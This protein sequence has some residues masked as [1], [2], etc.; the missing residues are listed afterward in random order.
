MARKKKPLE[1]SPQKT[2]R[3]RVRR[4][5]EGRTEL[6]LTEIDTATAPTQDETYQSL[7]QQALQRFKVSEEAE[8]RNRAEGLYDLKFSTGDGQWPADIKSQRGLD[9]RPCLTIPRL[10]QFI[11]LVSN[12][13]IQS[14]PAAQVNP[15]GDQGDSQVASIIQGMFRHIEDDSVAEQVYSRAFDKMLRKGW[16]WYRVLTEW[17]GEDSWDQKIVV[18]DI[19]NDFTV[20]CDPMAMLPDRSDAEWM[21]IVEDMP[22]GA[23]KDAYGDPPI[24]GVSQF[25]SV[26]DSPAVWISGQSIRVAEYYY[27]ETKDEVLY[28]LANGKGIFQSDVKP[29]MEFDRD[30]KGNITSRVATKR[31]LKWCKINANTV[32]EEPIDVPCKWIPVIFMSGQELNIDGDRVLYGMVR[33]ARDPQRMY[34]YWSSALTEAIALAPKA[35]FI[36]AAGQTEGFESYWSTANK[37]NWP[38]LPYKFTTINGQPAPKPERANASV[39]TNSISVAIHQADSDL[40]AT[41]GIYQPSLGAVGPEQSGK[42]ILARQKQSDTTNANYSFNR[43]WSLLHCYRVILDMMPHIYTGARA[44]RIVR[45][46]NQS[47]IV[48]INQLFPGPDGREMEYDVAN[49]AGRY[50]VTLSVGAAATRRQQAVSM[51]FEVLKADPQLITMFGDLLM[52]QMDADGDWKL[53]MAERFRKMLPPQLQDQSQQQ[54]AQQ[55]QQLQQL[56]QAHQMLTQAF[57]QA[58]QI[59]QTKQIEGQT[60]QKIEEMKGQFQLA[61]TK[62]KANSVES[63]EGLRQEYSRIKEMLQMHLDQLLQGNQQ[64]H[65]LVMQDRDHQNDLQLAHIAAD[66]KADST[67]S[68]T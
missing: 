29:F 14:R 34:N 6:R 32:I 11:K 30:E 50:S 7:V 2:I 16:S 25:T 62:L 3:K 13:E 59:I 55:A 67:P 56:L 8:T 48:L 40:M 53:Q 44:V 63:M 22:I 51:I 28:R 1:P 54:Q 58:Q 26:G 49:A 61:A 15:V 19:P 24:G 9:G 31:Q 68:N 60:K 47:E 18:R 41:M 39:D 33:H 43:N 12:D 64:S 27:F 45:T 5:T 66:A 65:E 52:D 23:Y 36:I 20:Y 17:E 10:D 35:P 37:R 42:A 4:T 38:F 57:Q 21:L 46:N